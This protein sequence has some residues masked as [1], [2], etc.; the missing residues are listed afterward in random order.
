[1]VS[2]RLTA[3]KLVI[4]S[5]ANIRF[6]RQKDARLISPYAVIRSWL[7]RCNPETVHHATV[8]ACRCAGAIPGVA[9]VSR[10]C[11]EVHDPALPSVVAG[12][13]FENPIGLAAGWDKSGR[14]LRLLDSL[15]FGFTEIGSVS[16]L[17]SVGNPKPR[18]FRVP[19]DQA[20]IVNYGLPNDGA[21]AVSRRLAS[22]RSRNPLGVNLVKTNLCPDA[23]PCSDEEILADYASSVTLTHR[24][25]SYLMLNLSCPNARGGK[26]FFAENHNIGRLLQA[27]SPLEIAC[28]VF[29]KIA[30]N[31]HP[32]AIDRL[33]EHCEP[34]DFVRGFC[35]NLPS[36][37][38][39]ELALSTPASNLYE[40]PGAV[41]GRPVAGLIDRCIGSLYRRMNTERYHIIGGGGV[42]TAQDAYQKIRSGASLVQLYTALVYEGPG[43]ARRINRGL[44][45]LLRRDG[46][47]RVDQAVGT[48]AGAEVNQQNT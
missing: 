37:R 14:A 5:Y 19:Q 47:D 41:S 33:L 12:L 28:P 22:H 6:G 7:F 29:L 43:I 13:R 44:V 42:F 11:F 8:E 48:A 2:F 31:D 4:A 32:A 10:R 20:I 15:G 34:F 27:L 3:L 36:G 24:R 17:A 18:L 30:P 45:E 46:F 23:P 9:A 21:E 38:P 40:K 26:D 25:A 16:A 1:M 35:F 39:S